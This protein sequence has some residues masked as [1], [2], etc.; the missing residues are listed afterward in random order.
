MEI[1]ETLNEWKESDNYLISKWF[2]DLQIKIKKMFESDLLSELEFDYF[3]YDATRMDTVYVGQLF[4]NEDDYQDKLTI[5]VDY[6][7]LQEEG[8]INQ[9]NVKFDSYDKNT[10][11]LIGTIN[12]ED[13]ETGEFDE[14]Y[15]IQLISDFKTEYIE[16]KT[17]IEEL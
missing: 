8:D 17:K 1:Y 14:N 15:I 4:F 11:E 9:F 13:V 5:L 3:E 16:D 6:A 10:D 2:H 12:R 7:Q